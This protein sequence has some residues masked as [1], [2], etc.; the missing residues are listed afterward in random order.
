MLLSAPTCKRLIIRRHR[1][2]CPWRSD[3]NP[4]GPR[5]AIRGARSRGALGPRD[6]ARPS[7]ARRGAAPDVDLVSAGVFISRLHGNARLLMQ[8]HKSTRETALSARKSLPQNGAQM[9]NRTRPTV[10]EDET[11]ATDVS[12]GPTTVPGLA[13]W[14]LDLPGLSRNS[15]FDDGQCHARLSNGSRRAGHLG[16]LGHSSAVRGATPSTRSE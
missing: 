8:L 2:Q 10:D 9:L 16:D 12:T 4:N 13:R 1:P 11:G 14:L 15:H 3:R 7:T 6:R 5:P